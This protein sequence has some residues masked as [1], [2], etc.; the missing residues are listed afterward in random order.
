MADKLMYITNVNTQII[1]S[2]DWNY[3]LKILDTQLN[4]ATNKNL[5][6]VPKVV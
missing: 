1:P 5:L 6:K 2:K 3:L 4:E